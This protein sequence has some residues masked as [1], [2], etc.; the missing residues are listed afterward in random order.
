M[1]T[2]TRC[3]PR[4]AWPVLLK[5]QPEGDLSGETDVHNQQ[6]LANHRTHTQPLPSAARAGRAL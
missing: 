4:E 5:D 6:A 2:T 3:Q 1:Q